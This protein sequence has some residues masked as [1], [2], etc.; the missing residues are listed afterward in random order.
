M[1]DNV[2]YKSLKQ[3]KSKVDNRAKCMKSLVKTLLLFFNIILLV[4][5]IGLIVYCSIYF[6]KRE[7]H[8]FNLIGTNL[9]L[10]YYLLIISGLL[11][12]I[13]VVIGFIGIGKNIIK[14]IHSYV[15]LMVLVFVLEAVSVGLAIYYSSYFLDTFQL[16]LK[17]TMTTEYHRD[18]N[19]Q[20][21]DSIDSLQMKYKCCGSAYYTDWDGSFYVTQQHQ[22]QNKTGHKSVPVTRVPESCCRTRAT[23]CG[24]KIHPSN[25]Y[26]QG[27]VHK[28]YGSVS[29]K[30]IW[31]GYIALA[32]LGAQLFGIIIGTV[33]IIILK[34]DVKYRI[35]YH[36]N[37]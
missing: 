7:T 11:L 3:Q 21:I 36:Q 22:Q 32:C 17:R 10:A 5:S 28:F 4:C 35:N 14:M 19:Q 15:I 27:C 31:V 30:L 9:F 23:G 26:H 29:K 20:M 37:T 13:I 1:N 33:L 25:I 18:G 8:V 24:S 34:N 12:I 16:D 2:N 6:Y